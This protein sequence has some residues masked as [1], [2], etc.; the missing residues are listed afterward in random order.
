VSA[1]TRLRVGSVDRN[2]FAIST[3]GEKKVARRGM[4][5]VCAISINKLPVYF[6]KKRK[7]KIDPRGRRDD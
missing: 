1:K 2:Y 6:K 7:R 3:H 5:V 4:E